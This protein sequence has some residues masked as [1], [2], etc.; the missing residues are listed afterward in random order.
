MDNRV[1]ST[2]VAALACLTVTGC[3]FFLG[4]TVAPTSGAGAPASSA[5]VPNAVP[6]AV[7]GATPGAAPGAATAA[8]NV[9]HDQLC[10]QLRADIASG[11]HNQRAAVPAT[12]TSIIAAASE[13][14]EDQKIEAL[15]KR[16]AELGCVSGA[17]PEGTAPAR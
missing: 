2:A 17:Q 4:R 15:Q 11:Q 5:S 14:K 10:S 13:G 9:G 3:T 16:Y 8:G 1:R 6:A 7:P 12:Q